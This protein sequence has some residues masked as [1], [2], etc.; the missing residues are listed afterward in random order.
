MTNAM[1]LAPTSAIPLRHTS[2]R[3][4]CGWLTKE[5]L[6]AIP[7]P[8]AKPRAT[9]GAACTKLRSPPC[10]PT[11]KNQ[12][13]M[14]RKRLASRLSPAAITNTRNHRIRDGMNRTPC[15]ARP[16]TGSTRTGGN[17]AAL[18]S[19]KDR[20]RNGRAVFGL[21]V[22][23]GDDAVLAEDLRFLPERNLAVRH[24]AFL[25]DGDVGPL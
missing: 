22:G 13:N 6:R 8:V 21:D 19:D 20:D 18:L 10:G 14:G 24:R 25:G 16:E 7:I 2:L 12:R 5:R 11:G 3:C 23:E 9:S 1:R 17:A 4:L 15:S